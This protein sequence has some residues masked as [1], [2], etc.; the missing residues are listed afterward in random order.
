MTKVPDPS[1]TIEKP[2]INEYVKLVRKNGYEAPAAQKTND[3]IYEIGYNDL[4]EDEYERIDLTL[5][6]D[7]ILTDDNDSP[8]RSP[9]FAVGDHYLEWM[10]GKDELFIRN[11]K[12]KIDYDITRSL[13]SYSSMLDQHPE[14]EQRLQ[15]EDALDDYYDKTYDDEEDGEED[16]DE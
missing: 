5:Y 1:L 12:R 7:G 16:D 2:D 11:E 4:D 15:Y 9:E 14:T 3:Y 10:N 6:A 8:L 13:L